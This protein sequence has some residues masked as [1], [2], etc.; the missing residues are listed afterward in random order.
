[1]S[2]IKLLAC[3]FAVLLALRAPEVA[4][5]LGLALQLSDLGHRKVT[6]SFLLPIKRTLVVKNGEF[7]NTAKLNGPLRRSSIAT[8]SPKPPRAPAPPPPDATQ[9]DPSCTPTPRTAR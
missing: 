2:A 3:T 9:G 8:H 1:V 4:A 7:A 6:G 5:A